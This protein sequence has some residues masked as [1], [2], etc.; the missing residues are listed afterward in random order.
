MIVAS[1][2]VTRAGQD[3][4]HVYWA[5]SEPTDEIRKVAALRET[6][7][8]KVG[9]DLSFKR[10]GQVIRVPGTIYGKA[11]VSKLCRILAHDDRR[12]LHL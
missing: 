6:I 8:R 10:P 1:G 5:L 9:G 7:A 4:L 2:G 12:E 11:G 3:K